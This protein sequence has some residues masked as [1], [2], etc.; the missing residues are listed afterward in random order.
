MWFV[1]NYDV[2]DNYYKYE[3]AMKERSSSFSETL[4]NHFDSLNASNSTY[5]T[6]PE[7]VDQ[8]STQDT[9]AR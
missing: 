4:L 9:M 7:E 2:K 6:V 1:W 3:K 5:Q 8:A